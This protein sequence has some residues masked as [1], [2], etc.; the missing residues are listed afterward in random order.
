MPIGIS[1][2]IILVMTLSSK[3]LRTLAFGRSD[4]IALEL[5]I[6]SFLYCLL[7]S[8]FAAPD[9]ASFFHNDLMRCLVLLFFAFV[10]AAVHKYNKDLCMAQVDQIVRERKTVLKCSGRIHDADAQSV[11]E[12]VLDNV[13]LLAR[14]SVDV[15]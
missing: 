7:S 3:F 2:A 9:W 12:V 4:S 8:L 6:C 10:V 11:E 15:W 13:G 1:F 14:A 5:C